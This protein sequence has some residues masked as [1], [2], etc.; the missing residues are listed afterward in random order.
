M[1][2]S[3]TTARRSDVSEAVI[4]HHPETAPARQIL[5]ADDSSATFF[6]DFKAKRSQTPPA[7]G[8]LDGSGRLKGGRP[9][10]SILEVES[11]LAV[12]PEL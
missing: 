1:R 10:L 12:R 5:N 6:N 4:S 3:F 7:S 9:S 2:S 8:W 11:C